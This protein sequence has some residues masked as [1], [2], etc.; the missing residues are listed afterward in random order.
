MKLDQSMSV[1]FQIPD[2]QPLAKFNCIEP[3]I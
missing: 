1:A 3:K 2:S